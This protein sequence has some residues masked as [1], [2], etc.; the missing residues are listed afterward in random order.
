MEEKD[1]WKGETPKRFHC[2]N[3]NADSDSP[4]D[5]IRAVAV[6]CPATD[7]TSI[8]QKVGGSTS[9]GGAGLL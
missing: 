7:L 4:A 2:T 8:Q 6:F 1:R 3:T 9:G 5:Y